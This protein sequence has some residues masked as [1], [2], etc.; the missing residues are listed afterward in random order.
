[1]DSPA[2]AAFD[3]G[4]GAS[5]ALLPPPPPPANPTLRGLFGIEPNSSL[6]RTANRRAASTVRAEDRAARGGTRF[7]PIIDNAA[8]RNTI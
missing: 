4:F 3:E 6:L 5:F 2:G 1:M 8:A 7:L